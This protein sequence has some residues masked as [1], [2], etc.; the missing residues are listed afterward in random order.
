VIVWK[1]IILLADLIDTVF[2][3]TSA[4]KKKKKKKKNNR[5]MNMNESKNNTDSTYG[6]KSFF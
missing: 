6:N 3:T 4:L 2:S 1:E 5:N